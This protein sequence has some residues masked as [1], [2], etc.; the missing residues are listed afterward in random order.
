MTSARNDI[1]EDIYKYTKDKIDEYQAI[2][3]QESKKST[4]E[5]H[6]QENIRAIILHAQVE[7]ILKMLEWPPRDLSQQFKKV[8]EKHQTA[9]SENYYISSTGKLELDPKIAGMDVVIHT[10]NFLRVVIKSSAVRRTLH[11]SR[12]E[13][14]GDWR[15][16]VGTESAFSPDSEPA[17]KKVD[18]LSF[19]ILDLGMLKPSMGADF[20]HEIKLRRLTIKR[21][22]CD[23]RSA[24]VFFGMVA[25]V[26]VFTI[27]PTVLR[28]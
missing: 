21:E 1:F 15:F 13:K 19:P 10:D 2:I 23:F 16:N 5:K 20:H 4:D 11:F 27:A 8:Q 28:P 24:F 25:A 17:V 9:L 3:K 18:R 14:N 22:K 6:I 26:A 12:D 7:E